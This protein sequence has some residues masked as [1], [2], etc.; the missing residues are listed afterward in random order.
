MGRLAAFLTAFTLLALWAAP[1]PARRA[2]PPPV[3]Y[4]DV[5]MDIVADLDRQMAPRLGIGSRDNS[6]G[7]YWLV[8]T[9][10]ANLEQLQGSSPLGRQMA[11]EM[12]TAFVARGYNV[13][14]I[15]R[16]GEIIFNRAE[17]EFLL[18]RDA[19]ALS[20]RR[21]L[22]TLIVA[23]TYAVTPGGVRFTTE[24]VDARNQNVV[25]AVSRTVP[26]DGLAAA[27][28]GPG[29]GVSQPTVSTVD[30]ET[31]RREMLPYTR[32]AMRP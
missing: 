27:M 21:P 18:T 11:Q 15:R 17:G 32:G 1:A 12:L 20:T 23:G 13:Q 30:A 6:R 31:F 5:A 22:A 26:L 19:A 25:A 14:E 3:Q 10:P 29:L 8:V 9:V 28:L 4:S 7:L 16:S 24:V 2:A